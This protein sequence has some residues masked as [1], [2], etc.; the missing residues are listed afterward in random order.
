MLAFY[1]ILSNSNDITSTYCYRLKSIN[2]NELG[3]DDLGNMFTNDIT[4]RGTNN[5][6]LLNI[7]HPVEFLCINL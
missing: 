2:C 4:T 7:S 5:Q 1:K 3:E 6:L